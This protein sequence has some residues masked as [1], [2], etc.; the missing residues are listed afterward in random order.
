ML[1]CSKC[2]GLRVGSTST[3][4]QSSYEAE[5]PHTRGRES[6]LANM[7]TFCG[8]VYGAF[9]GFLI[10]PRFQ[11][12]VCS[13]LIL[14]PL[15]LQSRPMPVDVPGKATPVRW[16]G[17]RICRSTDTP[18]WPRH[19]PFLVLLSFTLMAEPVVLFF[20]TANM[21]SIYSHSMFP[22][23]HHSLFLTRANKL[24]RMSF[25]TEGPLY[26]RGSYGWVQH[27]SSMSVVSGPCMY[28]YIYNTRPL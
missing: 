10:C 24:A 12:Y 1:L 23:T 8:K 5:I 13:M 20:L 7:K 22:R 18:E 14:G 9:E 26:P 16:T 15:G 6:I 27:C 3:T 4:Q 17:C 2:M 28:I 21:Y 19:I 25:K 11:V